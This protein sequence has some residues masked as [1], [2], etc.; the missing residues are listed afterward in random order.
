MEME[1]KRRERNGR[2]L[3]KKKKKKRGSEGE[4]QLRDGG[5]KK[6]KVGKKSGAESVDCLRIQNH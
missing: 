3:E 5:G 1:K 6:I 2:R 4:G